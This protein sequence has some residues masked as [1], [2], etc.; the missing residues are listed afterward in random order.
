M[1]LSENQDRRHRKLAA[2]VTENLPRQIL[3]GVVVLLINI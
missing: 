1:C 3:L 2:N